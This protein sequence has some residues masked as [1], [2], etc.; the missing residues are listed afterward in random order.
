MPPDSPP[1]SSRYIPVEKAHK[2]YSQEFDGAKIT[3]LGDPAFPMARMTWNRLV[4]DFPVEEKV[5]RRLVG[6]AFSGAAKKVYEEV[7]AMNLSASANELWDILGTKLFNQSQQRGQ[8]ASFYSAY[9]KEKSESIE[10]FGAR[11]Q[12]AAIALPENISEEALVHRFIEGLPARL[13][14]QALLVYGDFDEVVAKTSLVA[15]AMG[16]KGTFSTETVY[17]VQDDRRDEV[18]AR[19]QPSSGGPSYRERKCFV[20]HE[21]GHIAKYCPT[22]SEKANHKK[23]DAQAEPS[24]AEPENAQGAPAMAAQGAPE[25]N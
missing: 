6:L 17:A 22:K 24:K 11:L 16:T 18:Q 21:V 7:A 4:Q 15:K 13:K 5:S 20:C 8:R 2:V 23:N 19:Y 10:Q 1:P 3:K 25:R 14:T 12:T 9:W